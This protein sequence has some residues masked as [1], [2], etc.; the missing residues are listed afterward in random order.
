[1]IITLK[2]NIRNLLHQFI[3]VFLVTGCPPPSP[4]ERGWGD[5]NEQIP[6]FPWPPPEASTS[7]IL[8]NEFFHE[9][10]GKIVL[11]RYVDTCLS[12]ALG[13]ADYGDK[14]YY[15]VPDGFALVTRLEQINDDGTSKPEPDRWASEMGPLRNFSL[16]AYLKALFT[17]KPGLFRII[18]FI[19]TP[20]PFS[21]SEAKVS[22]DEAIEWLHQGLNKL[23]KSI[24]KLEYTEE[25]TCTALIYE[26]EK[27]QGKDTAKTVIP[28]RLS[29]STH[30]VSSE[31]M[32]GLKR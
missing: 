32:K 12:D 21:Q 31:I 4:V 26:F 9:S 29:A 22:R 7:A 17:N 18:V 11:L 30:L 28:G 24:G 6:Q 14:C 13:N 3:V 8:P 16:S 25:Y 15:A 19:V 1:M 23:P 20:H 10:S 27:K 5:P 2:M